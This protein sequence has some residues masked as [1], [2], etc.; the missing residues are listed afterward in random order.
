MSFE[1]VKSVCCEGIINLPPRSLRYSND[2]RRF[3]EV[4]LSMLEA[5]SYNLVILVWRNEEV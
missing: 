5:S 4:R 1:C 2:H 3:W